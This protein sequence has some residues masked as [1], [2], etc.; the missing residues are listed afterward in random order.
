MV[1]LHTLHNYFSLL[2]NRRDISVY[3]TLEWNENVFQYM[4][5]TLHQKNLNSETH[6]VMI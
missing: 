6:C 4:V 3:V 1:V 5:L 2:M